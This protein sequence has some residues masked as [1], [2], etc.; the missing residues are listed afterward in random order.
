MIEIS[1]QL[2]G[3]DYFITIDNGQ[4]TV[5][6]GEKKRF[7]EWLVADMRGAVG[8]ASVDSDLDFNVGSKLV[9]VT[10]GKILNYI[11]PEPSGEMPRIKGVQLPHRRTNRVEN[12]V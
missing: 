10:G 9:K 2:K 7:I 4:A 3:S 6:E 11:R 12:R 8:C 5:S 1:F